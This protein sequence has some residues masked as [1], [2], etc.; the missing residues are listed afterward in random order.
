MPVSFS[1]AKVFESHGSGKRVGKEKGVRSL[2]L[3]D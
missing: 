1:S 2:S 3:T